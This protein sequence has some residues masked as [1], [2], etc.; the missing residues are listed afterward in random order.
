MKRIN[1]VVWD[2][3]GG[4]SRDLAILLDVLRGTEFRVTV[5]GRPPGAAPT[6]S[7][8]AVA[9][10]RRVLMRRVLKRPLYDVNLFVESVFNAY[11]EHA[12]ANLL[13]P[14]LEWFRDEQHRYLPAI[15]GVLCK[16][17]DAQAVFDRL[18]SSTSYVGFTSC[19]HW[20][21]SVPRAQHQ[22]L[23]IAGRSEQK[24]TRTLLETW[25][26]HPEWPR[27]TVIQRGV[28]SKGALIEPVRAPNIEHRLD[29]VADAELRRL[30]S[31][32]A[33]TLCPSEAE[34]FGHCIVEALGCGGVTLTTDAPPMNDLVSPE[35]GLLVRYARS[36][37]QRLGT[38]YF[39]DPEDLEAKIERVVRMTAEERAE[40]GRRA[41]EWFEENDRGF[42]TR[43]VKVIRD[44]C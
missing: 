14:N 18:G 8:R 42:R 31:A 6:R 39:V 2:N 9:A 15:D 11:L 37:P 25:L 40:F 20:D 44:A 26:R 4:L 29:H 22:F 12:A 24:G 21:R 27:L 7:R 17:A 33:V 19:D 10:A 23:H 36:E 5:N 43:F 16:T 1:I 32:A 38:A 34:G 28:T 35:R 30:R 13:L 41:R 3:G